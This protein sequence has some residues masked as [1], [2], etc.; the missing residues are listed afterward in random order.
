[1]A[2]QQ[3]RVGFV[4]IFILLM[5]NA[6]YGQVFP[7]P[8][9]FVNDFAHVLPTDQAKNLEARLRSYRDATGI[10]LAVVT[11]SSLDDMPIEDYASKLFAQWGIGEKGKDNGVLMLLAPTERKVRIEVGYGLEPD[12]T[13]SESGQIIRQYANPNFKV[14]NWSAGTEATVNGIIDYL[15]S[16]P[17]QARVEAR[18]E[19][20]K[21]QEEERVR[22]EAQFMATLKYAFLVVLASVVLF[23]PPVVL[24]YRRHRRNEIKDLINDSIND[25]RRSITTIRGK[26]L[27]AVARLEQLAKEIT[28]DEYGAASNKLTVLPGK[29]SKTEGDLNIIA[30]D[31]EDTLSALEGRYYALRDILNNLVQLSPGEIINGIESRIHERKK[32][33]KKSKELFEAIPKTGVVVR[34]KALVD[35]AQITQAEQKLGEAESQSRVDSPNWLTI[36][37]LLVVVD[38]LLNLPRH[39]LSNDNHRRLNYSTHPDSPYSGFSSYDSGSS[40]SSFGGFGGGSSGGGGASGDF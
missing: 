30:V 29:I 2:R 6:V 13:D 12:L 5:T 39:S 35:E 40:N 38:R 31:Q 9:G 27:S 34:E 33:E 26:Y 18:A 3:V 11:V 8:V 36:Y 25:G 14:N 16:K 22:V 4:L 7:K 32:A 17:F 23:G 37:A 21:K 1:M 24:L 20:K 28:P 10:E 15:G 19:E